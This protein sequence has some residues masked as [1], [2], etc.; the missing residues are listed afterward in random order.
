MTRQTRTVSAALLVSVLAWPAAAQVQSIQP[1]GTPGRGAQVPAQPGV[2]VFAIE[3]GGAQATR[4]VLMRILRQ[5]PPAVG[6][7][8]Q[9]DPSLLNLPEYLA[10]YPQLVAFLRQHPE[11]QRNPSFFF[12]TY[13]FRE[14]SPSDRAYTMLED[15]VEGV[16]IFGVV[17]IILAALTWLIRTFVD[18]RRWLRLTRTQAEVHTKL[19]DRLT[20][21]EDLMAYMQS[22]AGRRFLES[23]PIA[24]NGEVR[25]AGAPLGRIILSLQAGVVLLALGTG[26]WFVQGQVVP[27]IGEGFSIIGLIVFALGVGFTASAAVA[28]GVSSRLGLV[29]PRVKPQ[30][31][32]HE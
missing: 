24:V 12:G 15:V 4:L 20:A 30:Q 11:I 6:E 22:P 28:Y 13:S 31:A 25:P 8:L 29:A 18:H 3:G 16:T 14:P 10:P 26:L 17:A 9:R 23:A 32:A 27:E 2:S 21:N 5:L 19:L 1:P 7:V